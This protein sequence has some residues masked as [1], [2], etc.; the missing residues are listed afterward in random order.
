VK[1]MGYC[2]VYDRNS[3]ILKVACD[4]IHGMVFTPVREYSA[5][6]FLEC[7]ALAKAD[8]WL[9]AKGPDPLDERELSEAFCRSCGA[10]IDW[11]DHL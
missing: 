11:D 9:L 4:G 1:L 7:I 2:R 6:T 8:G 3:V 10:S 5:G